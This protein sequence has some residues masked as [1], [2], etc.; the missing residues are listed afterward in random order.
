MNTQRNILSALSALS[1]MVFLAASG[2]AHAA[3]AT[4]V[5]Q[6][7]NLIEPAPYSDGAGMVE[8]VMEEVIVTAK[9]PQRLPTARYG[10]YPPIEIVTVT[11]KYP[12]HLRMEEVSETARPRPHRAFRPS[13][14]H[15]ATP[16][17]IETAEPAAYT[18][19][20]DAVVVVAYEFDPGLMALTAQDFVPELPRLDAEPAV[21]RTFLL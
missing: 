6:T 21:Q 8:P 14:V 18:I 7:G 4:P 10:E 20:D 5:P 1:A 2:T 11:A 19:L 12:E 15:R 13:R 16:P 3:A 17:S 9:Y